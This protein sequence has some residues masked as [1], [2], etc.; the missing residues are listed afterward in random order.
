MLLLRVGGLLRLLP[1]PGADPRPARRAAAPAV[2]AVRRRAGGDRPLGA[3]LRRRPALPA[4]RLRMARGPPVVL[5]QRRRPALGGHR[6]GRIRPRRADRADGCGRRRR[7]ARGCAA[8]VRQ[9]RRGLAGIRRRAI[10]RPR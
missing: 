1:R 8:G 6:G 3:A 10:P 7:L 9:L 2:R 4:A 5:H